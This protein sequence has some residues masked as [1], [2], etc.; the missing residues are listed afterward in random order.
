MSVDVKYHA[1]IYLSMAIMKL[2][3]NVFDKTGKLW[4]NGAWI[5]AV[6]LV[7]FNRKV[8]KN[9]FSVETNRLRMIF[10]S[11]FLPWRASVSA[12]QYDKKRSYPISVKFLT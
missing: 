2:G 12:R 4:D 3:K 6:D 10:M 9:H 5:T 1:G 8:R 11:S 7:C